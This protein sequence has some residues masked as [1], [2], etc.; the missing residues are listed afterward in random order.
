M[1]FIRRLAWLADGGPC[2]SAHAA[3]DR[4]AGRAPAHVVF[5]DRESQALLAGDHVLPH[6]GPSMGVGLNRPPSPLPDWVTSLEL[7]PG[8]ARR[9]AV[10]GAHGPADRLRPPPT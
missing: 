7:I 10:A 5:H 9:P 4:H 2:R 1:S 3:R 6:I 8:A